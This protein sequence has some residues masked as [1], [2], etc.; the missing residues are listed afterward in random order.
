MSGSGLFANKA[1]DVPHLVDGELK[2]LRDDVKA[3]FAPLAAIT[4]DEFTNPAAAGAADLEAATATTV[5]PRTVTSFL[6]GGLAKLVAFPRNITFTTAGGTAAD[7]PATATI[8]GTDPRGRAQT[9]TVTIAQTATIATGVKPFKTVTSIAYA[10]ADGTGATVSIGIGAG[11]GLG[12]PPKARA[13]AVPLAI[14]EMVDGGLVT[15]GALNANGLYTPATAPD[16]AHDYAVY[17]EYD[18][19]I[20]RN[21]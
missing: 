17:Y 15:T 9:E 12:M 2:D 20:V 4:V 21:A 5:A 19:S 10:A 16:G 14:R 1:G 18:P 11:L 7:A 13:G 3:E 6:A 8:T